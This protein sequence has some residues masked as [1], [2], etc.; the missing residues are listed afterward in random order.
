MTHEHPPAMDPWTASFTLAGRRHR[1]FFHHHNCGF[2]GERRTERTV[3][4]ALADA[5]LPRVDRPVIEIGAVTPYYWPGRVP[6]VVDPTDAH[7]RVTVQR[8]LFDVD[9]TGHDVL[10]IS[11]IEH[12]GERRYG[13]AEPRHPREAIEKIGAEAASFLVTFPIGW[14]AALDELVLAEKLAGVCATHFLVRNPDETWEAVAPM[15]AGRPYGG[16]EAPWAN[17]VC[18]LERGA[19]LAG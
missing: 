18:I 10:S 7:E 16:P 8:S 19:H 6:I 17:A 11:T 4:M 14:N 13:L 12:V 1:Y 15:M 3:E 2:P 9:L 5:W